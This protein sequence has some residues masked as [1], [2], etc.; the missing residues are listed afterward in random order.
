MKQPS[1]NLFLLIKSLT[2]AEKRHFKLVSSLQKGLKN[3]SQL[4][5]FIDHM[6]TYDEQAV[7]EHFKGE[8]FVKSLHVTKNYLYRTILKSLRYQHEEKTVDLSISRLLFEAEILREKGLNGQSET[9]LAKAGKIARKYE[10]NLMLLEILKKKYQVSS[11]INLDL[12][13]AAIPTYG[14]EA[15]KL[16]GLLHTEFQYRTIFLRAF[17][18][19]QKK[20]RLASKEEVDV[21]LKHE[22]LQEKPKASSF[23]SEYRHHG[24]KATLYLMNHDFDRAKEQYEAIVRLWESKPQFIKEYPTRYQANLSNYIACCHVNQD[25]AAFPKIL[26]KIRNISAETPEE[27]SVIFQNAAYYQLVYYM[28]TFQFDNATDLINEIKDGLV[29][30]SNYIGPTRKISFYHNLTIF[31]FAKGEYENALDWLN[32]ILHDR[33]SK[34]RQNVKRFARILELVLHYE[35]ENDRVLDYLYRSTYRSLRRKG[36][37]DPFEE[38]ILKF[39]KDLPFVATKKEKEKKFRE[40]REALGDLIVKEQKP[41]GLEE[42]YLWVEA[43]VKNQ[44]FI[45]TMKARY[46]PSR[47]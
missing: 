29:T 6:D 42:I 25:F 39:M 7:M 32:K 22:L 20:Q 8:K 36:V 16:I 12:E 46:G 23:L 33:R 15:E 3:Y 1:E 30:Y 43:K 26:E 28:N 38:T 14:Q 9:L 41:L 21:L 4:F 37:L 2:K 18:L 10:N 13:A 31:Y 17:R 5:D 27:K 47:V 45:E 34:P 11:E 44:T 24:S 35:L 40:F 19:Y